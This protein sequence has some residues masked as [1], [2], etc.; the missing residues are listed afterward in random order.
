MFGP[1]V[2]TAQDNKGY[3]QQ[4]HV[5]PTCP[6]VLAGPLCL[7]KDCR[8][9]SP[10]AK[11]NEITTLCAAFAAIY[12]LRHT[13]SSMVKSH[14]LSVFLLHAIFSFLPRIGLVHSS[15]L[16]QLTA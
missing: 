12:A 10:V 11:G 4:R 8:K 1:A 5:I 9:Y 2:T 3:Q 14:R 6:I 7:S 13:R 15:P 16:P